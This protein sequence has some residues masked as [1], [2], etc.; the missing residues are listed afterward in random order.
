M[1]TYCNNNSVSFVDSLGTRPIL[2]TGEKETPADYAWSLEQMKKNSLLKEYEK[3]GV[4]FIANEDGNGG[5]IENSYKIRS[6]EKRHEYVDYLMNDSCYASWFAGSVE[7][8]EF[9]W[10]V[11]N[12]AYDFFHIAYS[13]KRIR[14]AKNLD[15]GKTIYADQHGGFSTVMIQVFEALYPDEASLDLAIYES[16]CK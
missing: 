10:Y 11:H 13:P 8:F 3:K 4:R 9:E 1:F 16:L 5:T 6:D 7:G 2:N 12:V 14:Q 15:V